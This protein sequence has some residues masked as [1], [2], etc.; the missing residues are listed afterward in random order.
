M[1][2]QWGKLVQ[3]WGDSV[4]NPYGHVVYPTAF[5]TIAFPVVSCTCD[6]SRDYGAGECSTYRKSTTEFYFSIEEMGSTDTKGITWI[7]MGY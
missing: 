5:S 6:G 2:I 1:I 7:A 4:S 3:K